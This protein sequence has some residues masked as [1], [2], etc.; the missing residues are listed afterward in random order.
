MTTTNLCANI[1][2]L[3]HASGPRRLHITAVKSSLSPFAARS[4]GMRPLPPGN[5][6]EHLR[7]A[8]WDIFEFA[9]DPE[10]TNPLRISRRILPTKPCPAQ[11]KS[12]KNRSHVFRSDLKEMVRAG[13]RPAAESLL[14]IP[15]A[16]DNHPSSG[17]SH[18]ADHTQRLHLCAFYSSA[19]PH[20]GGWKLISIWDFW[21][22][23]TSLAR[24]LHPKSGKPLQVCH[25]DAARVCASRRQS[26]DPCV[27]S[28]TRPRSVAPRRV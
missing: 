28:D 2:Q 5:C 6:C 22:R 1:H 10:S 20:A 12:L 4:P 27:L 21:A 26:R 23:R 17:P 19:P 9:R 24:L 13:L 8:Q 3:L 15:T 25:P 7:I 18:S 11:R 14:T 16:T